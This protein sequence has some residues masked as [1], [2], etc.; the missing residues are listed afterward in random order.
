MNRLLDAVMNRPFCHGALQ[1]YAIMQINT[2]VYD[3]QVEDLA[4]TTRVLLTN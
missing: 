4:V 2:F 1:Y 3:K